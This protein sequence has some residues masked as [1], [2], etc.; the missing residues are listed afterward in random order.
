M[1]P[2]LRDMEAIDLLRIRTVR[3]MPGC[4]RDRF[5]TA[6]QAGPCWTAVHGG[7]VLACAGLVIYWH[8]RAGAWMLLSAD[9]PRRA[10]PWARRTVLEGMARARDQLGL[11]RIEAETLADWP[12]GATFLRGCGFHREGRMLQYSAEGD[13]YDRWAITA[14][15]GL[16]GL[17]PASALVEAPHG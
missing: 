1:T 11:R 10:W 4:W 8:G 13:D 5:R 16:A 14:A 9:F 17:R 2:F 3:P 15:T 7:Q 6:M 12:P